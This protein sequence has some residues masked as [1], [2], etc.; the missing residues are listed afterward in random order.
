MGPMKQKNFVGKRAIIWLE[1]I[2][3]ADSTVLSVISANA[4]CADNTM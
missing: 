2:Y 4:L 3:S 1:R